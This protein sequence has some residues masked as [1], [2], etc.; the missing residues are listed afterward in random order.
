MHSFSFEVSHVKGYLN[1]AFLRLFL[2]FC[3]VIFSNQKVH[4]QLPTFTLST[5]A[6]DQTCFGNGTISFTVTGSNPA[7]TITYA[8]YKLPD[9]LNIVSVTNPT[10]GL[11]SGT[12][13]VVATQTLGAASNTQTSDVI[14]TDS[15]TPFE[16]EITSVSIGCGASHNITV[17][18]TSGVAVSYEIFQGPIT[19]PNQLSPTFTNAPPGV[20][21]IRVFNNCGVG[22]VK[23]YAILSTSTQINIS[24]G[25]IFGEIPSCTTLTASNTLSTT[26]SQ[27]NYPLNLTYTIYPPDGSA[28]FT[29]SQTVNS[30]N[31]T[32]YTATQTMS[33][34]NGQEFVYDLVVVDNCGG[35]FINSGN[36][37]KAILS[38]S[39]AT[40]LAEC[41]TYFLKLSVRGFVSPYNVTFT[42]A[43]SGFVPTTFNANHPTFTLNTNSY[44][45]LTSGVPF[46][47]Y[48]VT[49]TDGCGNTATATINVAEIPAIPSAVYNPF[50]GC[51]SFKSKVT[52]QIPGYKILTAIITSAPAGFTIPLPY[53][54]SAMINPQ[55]RLIIPELS[56]GE[57]T[58]LL[59]DTCGNIYPPFIFTV[60]NLATTVVPS[61]RADC[62]SNGLSSV[63]LVGS[64][65]T[66]S[67]VIMIAAPPTFTLSALPYDVSFNIASD[68]KF[69]MDSLPVGNYS[70][71]VTDNC[72]YENTVSRYLTALETNVS[73][74]DLI[75]QCGSFKLQFTHASNAGAQRFW[76]QR[77]D[78]V[79]ATWGHPSFGTPY[80]ANTLPNEF[81]SQEIQANATTLNLTQTGLFR[82]IK[83]FESFQSGVSESRFCWETLHEFTFDGEFRIIDIFKLT[84]GGPISDVQ[85]LT[86]GVAPLIFK[87]IKKDGV[88]L[89]IDNGNNDIFAALEIGFYDFTVEDACGVIK[90]GSFDISDLPAI[91]TAQNPTNLV[92]CDDQSNDGVAIFNLTSQIPQIITNQVLAD[93][94]IS[95]YLILSDA[96]NQ[97]NQITNPAAFEGQNGQ[98][99]YV[100]VFH[101]G[102]C[103][104]IATFKIILQPSPQMSIASE[105]PLCVDGTT[106]LTAAPGFSSY[107]WSTGQV[108]QQITVDTPGPYS[109]TI[110]TNY[111]TGACSSVFQIN[112]I[113]SAPPTI[114]NVLV[115]DWTDNENTITV[116][117]ENPGSGAYVYSIDGTTWQTENVFTG[118]NAGVYNVYVN[119][120]NGCGNDQREVYILSYPKFFT[121]NDDGFND[122]WR[123]RF[124]ELEP[125]LETQIFDR[126]GKLITIFGT[127]TPGW[128]GMFNGK[129]VFAN[130]YWFLV[131]RQDGREL[132]GHFA[133]KR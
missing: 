106:T 45:S 42:S 18:V 101:K 118:L 61:S 107:L 58:I 132:K 28:S 39:F 95:F 108:S 68:G 72:N 50:P 127:N 83:S 70:F 97:L 55:G 19:Y 126:Y 34:Y 78:S 120:S 13:R 85:I 8:V 36:P 22:S 116:E 49:V 6:T 109:V 114:A 123:V 74:F 119:D 82:I 52:I 115:T 15:I 133:L 62:T 1:M 104:E 99:I 69:Y 90:V 125:L 12:Y 81:N 67:S 65:T 41:G 63:R 66:L 64:G 105:V 122:Y 11:Q 29:I 91:V 130:D 89:I 10:V 117:L 26:S 21:Q 4:A 103:F 17:N 111:S 9:L 46:G 87:I 57:Y 88:P 24:N 31:A 32:S 35:V 23:T 33:S 75:P 40:T 44:G 92:E 80:P 54:V 128:D 129:R 43:P 131:K 112:V 51:E 84:C 110:T 124:A 56:N 77:F 25:V 86:N 27:L 76:L 60:P 79:T 47:I 71:K 100:R 98:N 20:Y 73:S 16:Y 3:L 5:A 14:I 38:A 113:A 53:N 2:F 37:I 93:L 59:T 7:A 96:E 30:G 48:E 121:P 102:G 94:T